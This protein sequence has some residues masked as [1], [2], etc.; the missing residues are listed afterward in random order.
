MI[1]GRARSVLIL[2][3]LLSTACRRDASTGTGPTGEPFPPAAQAVQPAGGHPSGVSDDALVAF[4]VWQ[5]EYAELFSG[6]W[7]A[8]N[9]TGDRDAGAAL[10]D[11]K[12][13]EAEVAELTGRQAPVMKALLDRVPLQGTKAELATEAVGG[14]FHYDSTPAGNKLVVARDEVRL[15]AAR[16]RFGKDAIDDFVSRE[17]LILTALRG[18]RDTAAADAFVDGVPTPEELEAYV[19]G[20]GVVRLGMTEAEVTKTLDKKPGRRDD[21]QSSGASTDVAWDGLNGPRPG[22]ALGRFRDDRLY[23]IEFA[24]TEQAYPRLD[25]STAHSVT[26]ADYV[27]RSVART[28][29]M[30]DIEA[31]TRVPGYRASWTI[32]GGFG[33]PTRVQSMWVWEVDSGD[34]ILYVKEFDG[35]A[36]QPVIRNKR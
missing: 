27:R 30:A 31:V 35:L 1:A 17:P 23:S 4:V 16:R 8:L 3:F 33:S 25:Y 12:A 20:A 7:A 5:R 11:P 36:G 29:R 28:L 2:V 34:R 15:D 14:I 6:Q 10:R 18:G 19:S 24:P 13:F 32:M 9:S 26:Q 22:A 21:A